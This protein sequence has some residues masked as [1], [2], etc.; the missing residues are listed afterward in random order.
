MSDETMFDSGENFESQFDNVTYGDE[1]NMMNEETPGKNAPK[2]KKKSNLATAGIAAGAG[3][4]GA[5]GGVL[6]SNMANAT[7]DPADA[8]EPL[9]VEEEE[10]LEEQPVLEEEEP[11][12]EEEPAAVDPLLGHN[13]PVAHGVNDDMSFNE[14][15]AAARHEVGPGGLFEWHGQ[16]Y[17]TYYETEWN[18][19][20]QAEHDQYWADVNHTTV[21]S[22]TNYAQ[23]TNE[24]HADSF[25]STTHPVDPIDPVDPSNPTALNIDASRVIDEYDLDGDG[26][27]DVALVNANDN[28]IPDV[29]MDTTGNGQYDTLVVD[30]MV[31]DD[32]NL[33]M[34][35]DAIHEYDQIAIVNG[36][37]AP[38]DVDPGV[39]GPEP[40]GV[41]TFNESEVYDSADLDGDGNPDALIVD[42]DGNENLDLVLDTTGDGNLDTLILDPGVD[43]EGNLVYDDN[44]VLGVDG[45]VIT[46]D[47]S[48]DMPDD[49]YLADN[50]NIDD[51]AFVDYDPDVT[52]DNNMDMDDFA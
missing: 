37:D 24:G 52:I 8:G 10:P 42:A 51:N 41:L 12:V 26:N 20:S 4:A 31:D 30:P 40:F 25:G 16:V 27:P 44:S 21:P 46:P 14:A 15:F 33:V 34:S 43:A 18:A 2:S 6:F 29:I 3:V 5:A 11:V 23:N 7:E 22:D 45:V 38:I 13:M 9:V 50:Q 48:L 47:E 49:S 1:N 28:D 32:G 35:D 19:M 36:N 17:G 39:V